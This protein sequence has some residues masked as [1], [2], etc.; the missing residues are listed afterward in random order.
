MSNQGLQRSIIGTARFESWQADGSRYTYASVQRR[1]HGEATAQNSAGAASPQKSPT[2]A[3]ETLSA[4]APHWDRSAYRSSPPTIAARPPLHKVGLYFSSQT[5][6][7]KL[8][9]ARSRIWNGTDRALPSNHCTCKAP[10]CKRADLGE[11]GSP[12]QVLK[13]R[14]DVGFK[15]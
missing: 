6:Q 2:L 13:R 12:G 15:L 4:F 5:T 1:R 7:R 9:T 11:M 8:L 10:R 3:M 14:P